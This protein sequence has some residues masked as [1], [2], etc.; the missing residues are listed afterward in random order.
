MRRKENV[1]TLPEKTPPSTHPRP[2][3]SLGG[4]AGCRVSEDPDHALAALPS[5]HQALQGKGSSLLGAQGGK[6]PWSLCSS[7]ASDAKASTSQD[8][9]SWLGGHRPARRSGAA[10]LGSTTLWEM[11][12]REPEEQGLWLQL[13]SS[14]WHFQETW[15]RG[16]SGRR[17]S[18]GASY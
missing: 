6:Q 17:K 5:P 2:C 9:A 13:R 3:P 7:C 18:P 10:T 12:V 1:Q 11:T 15:H 16:G 8:S 14:P 4:R